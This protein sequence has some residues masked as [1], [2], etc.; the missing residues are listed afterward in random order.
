MRPT[1]FIESQIIIPF[2][3]TIEHEEVGAERFDKEYSYGIHHNF[4]KERKRT[5]C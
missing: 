3:R 4:G 5:E 2:G 1:R